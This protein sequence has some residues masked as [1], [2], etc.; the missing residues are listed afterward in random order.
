M[1]FES[2]PVALRVV[3][4]PY[5]HT[6]TTDDISF[7]EQRRISYLTSAS[8]QLPCLFLCCSVS[9]FLHSEVPKA[10]WEF[11]EMELHVIP[12]SGLCELL[13]FLI[14]HLFY[15]TG[16]FVISNCSFVLNWN[17]STKLKLP[18]KNTFLG[19]AILN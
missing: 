7:E 12:P 11:L 4:H 3:T 15:L 1:S 10:T 19:H 5:T 6:H 8:L 13:A 17:K 16:K 9:R 2:H 14:H 18:V